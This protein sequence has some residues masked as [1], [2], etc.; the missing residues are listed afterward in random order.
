MP[1]ILNVVNHKLNIFSSGLFKR[2]IYESGSPD[3]HWSYMTRTQ[4]QERSK[5]LFQAVNCTD[6]DTVLQCL[7][8]LDAEFI[9][10]NEWVDARFMVFPW[11]P[12]ADG[13]LILDS[14]YNLLQQ[15]CHYN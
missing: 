7:R 13:Q 6:D 14:P 8:G 2:A 4:A 15:V 11:A 10:N 12:T 5:Q 9:L 3:S 1:I